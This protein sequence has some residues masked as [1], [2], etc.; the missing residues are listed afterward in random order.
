MCACACARRPVL[1]ARSG[2]GVRASE[3]ELGRAMLAN[4]MIFYIPRGRGCSQQR[5]SDLKHS[6][7]EPARAPIPYPYC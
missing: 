6:P 4:F 3:R 1:S 2:S 5:Q 7:A